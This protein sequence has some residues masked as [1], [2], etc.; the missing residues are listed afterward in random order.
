MLLPCD[1][2]EWSQFTR[3]FVTNFQRLGLKKLIS[4]SYAPGARTKITL[5]DILSSSPEYDVK[6][7]ETHGRVLTLTDDDLL[8]DSSYVDVDSM[9]WSYL[10]G[11][12]DFRSKEV[13]ALRDEAD[14]PIQLVQCVPEVDR[15]RGKEVPDCRQRERHRLQD[16]LR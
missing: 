8:D 5:L 15:R 12:G 11:T 4:T 10:E 9:K 3:Y 2:P 6:K 1:D 13:T 14:A 16:S 7:Q